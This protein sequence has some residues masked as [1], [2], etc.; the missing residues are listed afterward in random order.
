ME[1]IRTPHQRRANKTIETLRNFKWEVLEHPLYSPNLAPRDFH[2][3]GPL[4]HHLS[5]EHFPDD[6][7]VEREITVLLFSE[8]L[9]PTICGYSCN[10]LYL[11]DVCPLLDFVAVGTLLAGS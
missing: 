3:F 1:V 5:T 11:L 4:K 8:P 10:S 7:A 9:D 6:E 2:L